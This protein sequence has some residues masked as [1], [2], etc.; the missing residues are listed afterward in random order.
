MRST[1][2]GTTP[3][4]QPD[5]SICESYCL[6]DSYLRRFYFDTLVHDSRALAFL[7][8]MVGAERL[9]FGT[10]YPYDMGESDPLGMLERAGLGSRAE[11][12]GDTAA[13]LLGQTNPA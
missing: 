8:E 13:G 12:L 3:W 5:R 4:P 2:S 6:T 7:H 10:D 1:A 9:L 11:L